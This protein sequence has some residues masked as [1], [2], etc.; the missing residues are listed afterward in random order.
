MR[1]RILVSAAIGVTS[2]MLCWFLLTRLHQG[3]ADFGWA[4]H[5][6]RA[7]LAHRNPYDTRLE[8]YPMTAAIFALPFVWM[9]PEVAGASFY[10][11]SSA[12]LAF[13][14]SRSG[15]HRLLVFLCFPY[16][17]GILTAQWAPLITA[18]A[19]FPLALP[20]TM[21][22]PQV[23][24]PVALTHLSWKGVVACLVVLLATFI[25]MPHWL[26]WWRGQLGYYNHYIPLLIWPGPL[27]ALALVRW[28]DRDAWLLFLA[29][30]MPQR[31]F[32]D[33]LILWL[34]PKSRRELV[35]T[36]AFSWGAG[37]W[38][39]YHF[40]HDF[41]EVGRWAVVFIYL[42]MLGVVLARCWFP[43][44]NSVSFPVSERT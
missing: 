40:P 13:G 39:W 3:A 27:I 12:L 9:R 5:N 26:L 37:I 25:A 35:W 32:F 2:G 17:I 41:G 1:L 38:R 16:C 23:G 20:F 22:K 44:D 21:A 14:L 43:P 18:S 33:A 36:A 10:G 28:R 29:A 19:L 34:I 42:P 11:L 8:Q 7:L 4:L 15:Y 31:W 6:A 30:L 24:L